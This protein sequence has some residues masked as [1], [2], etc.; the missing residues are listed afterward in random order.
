M[1]HPFEDEDGIVCLPSIR[2]ER[3]AHERLL[4][5]LEAAWGEF[6]H[7][8]KFTGER[9]NDVHLTIAEKRVAREQVGGK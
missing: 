7:D 6:W 9:I 4:P 2:G 8:G 3:P 1:L 5:L